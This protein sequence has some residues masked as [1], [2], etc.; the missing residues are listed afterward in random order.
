M[1]PCPPSPWWRSK[2]VEGLAVGL[3]ERE[4][5]SLFD[6]FRFARGFD[7]Y[8][9]LFLRFAAKQTVEYDHATSQHRAD[10][11][12]ALGG[13]THKLCI[14]GQLLLGLESFVAERRTRFD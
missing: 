14:V 6:I 2:H 7:Y 13:T 1:H 8:R 5:D 10:G 3:F 4:R 9:R 11:A 12:I